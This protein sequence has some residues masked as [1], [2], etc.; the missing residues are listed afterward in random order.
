MVTN[1]SS[2]TTTLSSFKGFQ[3]AG[4]ELRRGY[5]PLL[6]LCRRCLLTLMVGHMLHDMHNK[7][8]SFNIYW[9]NI[10]LLLCL[11]L[12]MYIKWYFY[13]EICRLIY[14]QR[15]VLIKVELIFTGAK[16]H[17][18]NQYLQSWVVYHK[19]LKNL[20]TYLQNSQKI[21]RRKCTQ[22]ISYTGC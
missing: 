16:F 1:K 12:S 8:P 10:H 14:P 2:I 17:K 19:I 4:F 9:T 5:F 15:V 6:V 20:N 22:H 13:G 3:Y 21:F 7:V 18:W 11:V